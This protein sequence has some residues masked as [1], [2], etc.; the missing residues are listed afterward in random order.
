MVRLNNVKSLKFFTL[1]LIL[2]Q[3]FVACSSSEKN[4]NTA[5]GLFAYAKE[6]D[7]A[8]R[9]EVAL[10]KYTDVRNKF[11]YSSL[12]TEAELAIADVHFKRESYTESEIAYQNFRDL[13]PKHI[14]SD[15]VLFRIAMSYF[16][17]LPETIDRDLTSGKDAIYHFS[18]LLKLYPQSEFATEAKN[19]K[20]DVINRQAQKELYIADFYLKQ[21]K[22]GAAFGRYENALKKFPGIGFDPKAHLGAARSAK[23]LEDNDNQKKHVGILFSKYSQSEEAKIAQK[24]GL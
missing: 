5:E 12:A 1:L 7:D 16:M 17:Q 15:Y 6:F 20:E 19:K 14:K 22:F 8:E 11:P 18:E 21:K 24:E 4:L 9:Y 13:H 23:G 3:F 2:I 10:Q